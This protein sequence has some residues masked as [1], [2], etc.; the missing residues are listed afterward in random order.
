[1]RL[2]YSTSISSFV[3]PFVR[4]H[5]GGCHY[6]VV[7][8][9]GRRSG[10][11][12]LLGAILFCICP[13]IAQGAWTVPFG[14]AENCFNRG[15]MPA[16]KEHCEKAL[17]LAD[18]AREVEPGVVQCFV[19]LA[20]INERL[21]NPAESER[22][23]ELAMRTL[24]AQAGRES[25]R[26][27]DFMPDLGYLY[28]AHHKSAKAEVLFKKTIAVRE[29][30]LGADDPTVADALDDYAHFLDKENRHV[31]ALQFTERAT[32]IRGKH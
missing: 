17:K 5:F 19:K 29:K 26:F 6:L 21:G 1:M 22:L 18:E 23:Y 27:A 13:A 12:A 31:E 11:L 28:Q 20:L 10:L 15:D 3:P 7:R 24:E 14:E 30:I 2:S 32:S 25:L 8:T 16:A 9:L 4:K